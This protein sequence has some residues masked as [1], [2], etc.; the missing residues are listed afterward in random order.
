MFFSSATSKPS[1][2][3]VPKR[4]LP[5]FSLFQWSFYRNGPWN[6]PRIRSPH[7]HGIPLQQCRPW[8]EPRVLGLYP[9]LHQRGM[10]QPRTCRLGYAAIHWVLVIN[11][12]CHQPWLT[13]TVS[14]LISLFHMK[15]W[16]PKYS[17]YAVEWDTYF[18]KI[19]SHIH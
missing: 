8:L 6:R 2:L 1:T 5:S 15:I 12:S 9:H 4:I 18:I 17:L 13:H 7:R 11:A 3:L 10:G 19:F 16:Q 14:K